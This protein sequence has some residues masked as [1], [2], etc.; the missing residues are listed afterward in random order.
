MLLY[1]KS[2]LR[3]CPRLRK[4]PFRQILF[5]G[6]FVLHLEILE[7]ME[8]TTE[9]VKELRDETGVSIMQC[10]KALEEAGGDKQ[11]ALEILAK[12]S[13]DIAKKKGDRTFGA[14]VVASYVHNTKDVGAMVVLSCETDFVAKNEEF[15]KL[16]SDI[17]MH[18]AAMR[19]LYIRR[20]DMPEDKLAELR[21]S[22][23]GEV[24]DKPADLQ[25]KILD[26]KVDSALQA[27]VLLEQYFIKDDSKTIQGLID[28]AVQKFGERTD[29]TQMALFTTK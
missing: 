11:K 26:G 15:I 18:M 14:G 2:R 9:A 3:L 22:F 12:K 5:E 4:L 8:I 20:N 25:D 23:R 6:F 19:P 21:E 7:Y 24:A 17:A 28:G 29:V 16:A 10:K 27:S 1:Q 13:G